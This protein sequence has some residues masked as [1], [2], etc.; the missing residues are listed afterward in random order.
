MNNKSADF[1]PARGPNCERE[2][3]LLT[4][5]LACARP[6]STSFKNMSIVN[7]IHVKNFGLK[8]AALGSAALLSLLEQFKRQRG[9][10]QAIILGG[11]VRKMSQ[12]ARNSSRP[13]PGDYAPRGLSQSAVKKVVCVYSGD[14]EAAEIAQKFFL[15]NLSRDEGN[16]GRWKRPNLLF[17]RDSL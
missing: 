4:D 13:Q 10:A 6:P 17:E 11:F 7:V 3:F 16:S 1:P 12:E 5:R 15:M 2:R 8:V 14:V 9:S